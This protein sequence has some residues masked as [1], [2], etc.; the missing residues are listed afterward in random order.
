GGGLVEVVGP[1]LAD[2][3]PGGSCVNIDCD[4]ASYI[5]T[6]EPRVDVVACEWRASM[7][8]VTA[9]P[10][11]PPIFRIKL[12]RLV[13]F[14]IRSRGIGSMETGVSGTNRSDMPTP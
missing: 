11:L 4:A 5:V 8:P 6:C 14:P 2:M 10:T 12:N 1:A 3:H 9:M 7:V 13:A